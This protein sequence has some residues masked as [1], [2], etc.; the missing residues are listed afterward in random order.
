MLNGSQ[1]R[2]QLAQ[3]VAA[4][5]RHGQHPQPTTRGRLKH[6]GRYLYTSTR[7]LF[8]EQAP[9]HGLPLLDEHFVHDDRAPEPGMSGITDFSR[10][11]IVG[12]ALLTSTIAVARTHASAPY[13]R[14]RR[15]SSNDGRPA[16][17]PSAHRV[18]AK[19]VLGGLFHKYLI[20]AVAA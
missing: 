1:Q 15:R 12:V 2:L 16:I 20:D 13:S 5:G 9:R 7:P 3:S 18:A 8:L 10:F 6:P 4:Y 14:T 11:S 17:I 19:P